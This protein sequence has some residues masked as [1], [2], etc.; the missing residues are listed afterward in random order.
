MLSWKEKVL[1]HLGVCGM[2]YIYIYIVFKSYLVGRIV[3]M[4]K[5]NLIPLLKKI[6]LWNLEDNCWLN[7]LK[8][9]IFIVCVQNRYHLFYIN[10]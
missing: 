1:F 7:F 3:E 5:Y 8:I 2:L 10:I 9:C 4:I 6:F